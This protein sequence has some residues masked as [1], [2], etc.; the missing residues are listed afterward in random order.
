VAAFLRAL[1]WQALPIARRGGFDKY[2]LTMTSGTLKERLARHSFELFV[3]RVTTGQGYKVSG[4][5]MIVLM[6]TK[7]FVAEPRSD[8]AATV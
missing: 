3:I 8:R 7:V 2:Y 1:G 5:D 4:P 6:I